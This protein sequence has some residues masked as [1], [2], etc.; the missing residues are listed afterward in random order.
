MAGDLIVHQFDCR[1][2]KLIP[3]SD[4]G[5]ARFAEKTIAYVALQLHGRFPITPVYITLGNNDSGCGDY[6]LDANSTF[7]RN[8]GEAVAQGWVNILEADRRKA[9]ADYRAYG[10]YSLP[11]PAPM[12]HSRILAFDDL[13][14]STRYNTCDGKPDTRNAT[15]LLTWLKAQLADA[16]AHHEHVWL[17]AHIP[18][19]INT[20]TTFLRSA[21]VCAETRP[22]TRP[23]TL[24]DMFLSSPSLDKLLLEYA[25]TIQLFVTGHTHLDELHLEGH[26]GTAEDGVVM[27]TIPSIS[28]ISNNPPSFLTGTV[29][30]ATATLLD[31]QLHTASASTGKSIQWSVAYDFGKTYNQPAL[32]PATLSTLLHRFSAAQDDA[33]VENYQAHMAGGLR[34]LALKAIW[35]QYVCGMQHSGPTAFKQCVC[36]SQPANPPTSQ[37]AK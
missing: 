5:L 21:N 8:T 16:K 19:G 34:L 14:L 26:E 10:S 12:E 9:L 13:F 37:R 28:P 2:R 17:L 27:K 30:P 29:D 32:T 15:G 3:G 33:A 1:Y 25:G 22:E 24:P 4:S 31:N 36:G 7:L 11:L 20:Y 35:P 23:E 18:T 6:Q